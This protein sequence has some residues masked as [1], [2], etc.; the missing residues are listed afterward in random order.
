MTLGRN[1]RE[2][3]RSSAVSV[4]QAWGEPSASAAGRVPM[5]ALAEIDPAGALATEVVAQLHRGA[6]YKGSDVRLHRDRAEWGG[7]HDGDGEG[8]V[9]RG[10]SGVWVF[11][12]RWNPDRQPLARGFSRLK[13]T[14]ISLKV[15]HHFHTLVGTTEQGCSRLQFSSQ[16]RYQVRLGCAA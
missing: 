7:E 4:Q 13:S 16:G 6:I 1:S 5:P 10:Q 12:H 2:L 8:G 15:Y 9:D 14:S 11:S 3:R